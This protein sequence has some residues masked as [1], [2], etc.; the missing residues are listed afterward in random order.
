MPDTKL[1]EWQATEG[2]SPHLSDPVPVIATLMVP[3]V[4]DAN[5]FQNLSIYLPKTA[6]T[7]RL[8]GTSPDRLPISGS[9]TSLPHYH[10]HIHGGAWREPQLTSRSIEADVA[11]AFSG[12][13]SNSQLDAIVGINY[14]ISPF[15]TH[16]TFPYNPFKGDTGQPEREAKHPAHVRDVLRAFALLQSLGLRD[17]GYILSGHSCGACLA[18]QSIL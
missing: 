14:T 3:Y 17:G 4:S 8:I 9:S 16:P 1:V 11:H 15:P 10:V 5:R 2:K 18:F 7:T 6:E 12:T 13:S